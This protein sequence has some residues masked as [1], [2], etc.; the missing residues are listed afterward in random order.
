MATRPSS[1]TRRVR[2]PANDATADDLAYVIHTSGS[3]GRPKAVEI[4]H[5]SVVNLLASM[6][7]EP[8]FGSGDT[9]LAVT[10]VSFDIAAL[11]LFLPLLAGGRVVIASREAAQDPYLL[12]ALIESSGCTVMQAQSGVDRRHTHSTPRALWRGAFAA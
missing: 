7:T 3:T 11:E 9:L 8:G 4:T 6:Q 1:R 5:A 2:G 12:A 10:T